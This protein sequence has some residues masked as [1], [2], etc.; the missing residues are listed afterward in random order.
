MRADFQV[1]FAPHFGIELKLAADPSLVMTKVLVRPSMPKEIARYDR[2]EFEENSF[3]K[4]QKTQK[5]NR[6]SKDAS[7]KEVGVDSEGSQ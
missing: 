4:K 1:S 5:Q 2:K 7:G 6:T 3:R